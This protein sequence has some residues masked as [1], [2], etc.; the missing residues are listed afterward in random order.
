L[1]FIINAFLPS[2]RTI[3]ITSALR[4]FVILYDAHAGW[5]LSPVCAN[6]F[7]CRGVEML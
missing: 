6:L 4:A 3:F 7:F 5:S 1:L 2:V